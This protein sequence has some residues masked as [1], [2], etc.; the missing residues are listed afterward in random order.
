MENTVI[1]TVQMTDMHTIHAEYQVVRRLEN[2][3]MEEVTK[4]TEIMEM[5]VGIITLVMEADIIKV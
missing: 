5:A 1:H 4:A 3:A 2:T